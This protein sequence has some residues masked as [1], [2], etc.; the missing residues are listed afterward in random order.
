MW[1]MRVKTIKSKNMKYEYFVSYRWY[2]KWKDCNEGF[3]NMNI[4]LDEKI[5]K[6]DDIAKLREAIA[7]EFPTFDTIIILFYQEFPK[8][9]PQP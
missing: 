5:S 2:G 1:T 8:P 9:I 6:A 4:T 7:K 3:G